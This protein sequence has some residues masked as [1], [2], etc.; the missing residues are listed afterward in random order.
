MTEPLHGVHQMDAE[1]YHRRPELSSS[2][3][4][5]LLPPNCPALFRYEQDHQRPTKRTFEIGHAAHQQVLGVGPELVLVD[6]DRWDTKAIKEELADIRAA[7]NVPLK[8]PEFEQVQEMARVLRAHPYAGALFDPQRGG[9]AEQSLFWTDAETGVSCR[10]RL[11]WLP[12]VNRRGRMIIP[13]Y[14]SAAAVDPESISKALDNF[15]Y[16]MQ[17]T[18]YTDAVLALGLAESAAFL[19]VFQ[20]KT[21][22]FLVTVAEV[23]AESRLAGRFYN[24]QARQLFAECTATDRWPGFSDD[25]P[26]PISLPGYALNQY[27]ERSGQ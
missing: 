6:A 1:T 12:A 17:D 7:G 23:V 15:G 10:A 4:K 11:D 8:R 20:M 25:G 13:D 19:F 24:R 5:L 22:P 16:A 18:W 3:A 26:L 14:K 9:K 21:P 27:Y 2:G